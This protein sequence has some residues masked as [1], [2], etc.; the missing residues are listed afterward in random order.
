MAGGMAK[1]KV[2]PGEWDLHVEAL[3]ATALDAWRARRDTRALLELVGMVVAAI[4]RRG[5]A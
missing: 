1:P 4:G 2:T 5:T 3:L